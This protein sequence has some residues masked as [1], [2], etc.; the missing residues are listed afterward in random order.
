MVEEMGRTLQYFEWK[1]DWWLAF[2]SDRL[3]ALGECNMS[4]KSNTPYWLRSKTGFMPMHTGNHMCIMTSLHRSSA[5]GGSTYWPILLALPGWTDTHLL[6]TPPPHNLLVD[7]EN[8]ML[9]LHLSPKSLQN[10]QSQNPPLPL[11]NSM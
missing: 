7:I 5:T 8:L 1:R 10:P 3:S 2:V 11:M 9:D 4:S 6:L